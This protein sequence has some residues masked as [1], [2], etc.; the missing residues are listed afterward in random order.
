MGGVGN[1]VSRPA[2]MDAKTRTARLQKQMII[3]ASEIGLQQIM[4]NILT[5]RFDGYAL[6]PHGFECL[7]G[8]RA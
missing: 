1:T 3:R 2:K 4:I 7:H 8:E 6:N 5:G